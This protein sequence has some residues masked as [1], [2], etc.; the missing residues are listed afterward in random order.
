[1]GS[2]HHCA[3]E[4][5]ISVIL[6]L[7]FYLLKAALHF[8]ELVWRRTVYQRESGQLRRVPNRQAAVFK[9]LALKGIE[10]LNACSCSPLIN[11]KIEI[12]RRQ[13]NTATLAA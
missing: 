5:T 7:S 2:E 12:K 6:F 4:I 10:C 3:L 1:M 9:S 8:K 11:W 13:W